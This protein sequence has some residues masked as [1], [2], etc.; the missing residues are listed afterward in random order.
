MKF[1]ALAIG[2]RFRFQGGEYTKTSP[3]MAEPHPLGER[4]LMPRSAEVDP[5]HTNTTRIGDL[6]DIPS[7]IPRE[8]LDR[9]MQ[10]LAG[11]LS[12]LIARSGLNA[13]QSSELAR[14]LQRAF[15]RARQALQLPS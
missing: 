6:P 9:V 4:R 14:D 1:S 12:E 8:Q 11:E 15:A 10:Q 13:A 5:L 3:L 7:E 2:A